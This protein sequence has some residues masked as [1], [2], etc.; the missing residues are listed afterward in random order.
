MYRSSKKALT[1]LHS[2]IPVPGTV[3]GQGP[4]LLGF[5]TSPVHP[6]LMLPCLRL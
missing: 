2:L 4:S 1:H 6:I 5:Y 3:P